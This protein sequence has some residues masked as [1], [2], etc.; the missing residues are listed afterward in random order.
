M[1]AFLLVPAIVLLPWLVALLASARPRARDV[2]IPFPGRPG[3]RNAI[4]D[5]EGVRVGH[6][7]RIEGDSI[8]TGVTAIV[9]HAGD[10]RAR[11]P[12]VLTEP[13]SPCR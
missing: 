9:P 8:R 3:P 12:R 5:V 10:L 7:T 2:G 1:L 13:F 4:T 6:A 11:T